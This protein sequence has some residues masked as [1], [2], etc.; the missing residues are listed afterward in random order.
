MNQEQLK[1]KEAK[2]AY[3]QGIKNQNQEND[4]FD[5]DLNEHVNSIIKDGIME[6]ETV[7]D[8]N[9]PLYAS[10]LYVIEN[11]DGNAELYQAAWNGTVIEAINGLRRV[12]PDIKCIRRC[13]MFARNI[14]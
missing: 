2:A 4:F 1:R 7:L 11:N 12:M 14:F 10:Y 5:G 13:N 3:K 8:G 6:G 9:Y